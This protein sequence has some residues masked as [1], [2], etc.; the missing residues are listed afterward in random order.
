MSKL[1]DFISEVK[2]NGLMR[3]S[4]YTV[5][6]PSTSTDSQSVS[7]FCD[8]V[9]LPGLSYST[10]AHTMIGESR[11]VPYTRLFDTLNMSF[12]V[13]NDMRVKRF[14]EDWQF[15]VQNPATRSF[16]YYKSYIKDIIVNVEDIADNTKYSIKL[17]E[18]YPKT[19][20]TV[21]MD[22]A[23]RDVMK[24]TVTFAYKYWERSEIYPTTEYLNRTSDGIFSETM[25]IFNG[26]ANTAVGGLALNYGVT[27]LQ[28]YLIR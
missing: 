11:E 27:K 25:G 3:T 26:I 5:I 13:D 9:P 21:Q 6:I 2:S 14:F 8:Q 23:S 10:D 1:T 18:C 20:G 4:R 16:N 15:S 12:Y 7:L 17:F 28:N 22:Y 24:L 19:V